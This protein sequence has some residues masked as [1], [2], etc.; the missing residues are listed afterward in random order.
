M[1]AFLLDKK[2][3]HISGINLEMAE[4]KKRGEKKIT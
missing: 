1:L 3:K 2:Y 4:R